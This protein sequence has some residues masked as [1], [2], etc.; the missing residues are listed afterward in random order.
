MKNILILI[1][2][3]ALPAV[4]CISLKDL[5]SFIPSPKFDPVADRP[6]LTNLITRVY[7]GNICNG[8]KIIEHIEKYPYEHQRIVGFRLLFDEILKNSDLYSVALMTLAWRVQMIN[9]TKNIDLKFIRE[10]LP[11]SVANF[12]WSHPV[13]FQNVEY[14]EFIYTP[15]IGETNQ[16]KDKRNRFIYAGNEIK[17]CK[18][19]QCSYAMTP[20]RNSVLGFNL[21]NEQRTELIYAGGNDLAFDRQRRYVFGS[22]ARYF[23]QYGGDLWMFEPIENSNAFRVYNLYYDEYMMFPED[24]FKI[25]KERRP[26]FTWRSKGCDGGQCEFYIK[27][28]VAYY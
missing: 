16:M 27:A 22:N 8:F 25:D 11:K 28:G 1:L 15:W 12:P 7:G 4:L 10:N 21:V 2:I 14:K 19:P 17:E 26:V 23:T 24:K 9:D 6:F 3:T 5:N 13:S 20:N 18:G